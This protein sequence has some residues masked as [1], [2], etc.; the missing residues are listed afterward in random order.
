MG[1]FVAVQQLWWR[2]MRQ[3]LRRPLRI[4]SLMIQPMMWLFLFGFGLGSA[5]DLTV[6]GYPY[7]LFILPGILG[8]KMLYSSS[9]GGISVLRDRQAGFLKEVFV[10]PVSRM[11]ILFGVSMGVVTRA[12]LQGLLLIGAGAILGLRISLAQL[13]L[14][15]LVM[16]LIGTALVMIAIAMAWLSEDANTY[17]SAANFVI[18][19]LFLLSGA[20]FPIERLPAA[21]QWLVML[22]PMSYAVDALRQIALGPETGNF[23]LFLDIAALF[24]LMLI[25]LAA[26][27]TL[28]RRASE[29]A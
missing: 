11:S 1:A 7:I 6:K 19:P 25:G 28:L 21:M 18:F 9:R 17:G 29:T 26:G 13:A 22:N 5:L 14:L 10:A 16:F 27:S 3:M 20:L 12:I 23:P 2:E 24:G 15:V 8:M 4:A